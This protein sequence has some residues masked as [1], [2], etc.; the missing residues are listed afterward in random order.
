MDI[1]MVFNE[2]SADKPSENEH[3]ARQWMS[4]F[5]KTMVVATRKYGVKTVLRIEKDFY[6]LLLARDYR[7]IS[8]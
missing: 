4:Q 3:I 5:I 8:G 1:E 6:D 2:L 7:F